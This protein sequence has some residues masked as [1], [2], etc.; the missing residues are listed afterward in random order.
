MARL[1]RE[2]YSIVESMYIMANVFEV[3]LSEAKR[4]AMAAG[5][6]SLD[7]YIEDFHNDAEHGFRA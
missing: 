4:L 3:P 6:G 1:R 5:F 7:A 2:E